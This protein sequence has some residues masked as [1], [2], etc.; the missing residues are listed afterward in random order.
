MPG[1]G[2]RAGAELTR[3]Q[4]LDAS[5]EVM[6]E[7]NYH[8]A[9]TREIAQRAGVSERMVFF[10]FKSKKILYK[11]AIKRATGDM[12]EA[13]QR[14]TPP[15]SDIRAFLKMSERNFLAFLGEE[16]L[17]VKLLFQSLDSLG[18]EELSVYIRE[19]FQNFFDL[20][21]VMLEKARKRGEINQDVSTIAAVVS[22]IGFHFVVAYVEFLGLDWFKDEQND[23]YSIVDVFADFITARGK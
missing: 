23:I 2:K 22:I 19:I 10:Y 9:T 15:R 12:L 7:K 18:D 21:Y 3:K 1:S 6:G 20:F 16:P 5:M 17:K 8:S 14:A 4:I 11:E 13:V